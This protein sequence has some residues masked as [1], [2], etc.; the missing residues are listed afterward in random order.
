MESLWRGLIKKRAILSQE[1]IGFLMNTSEGLSQA[2]KLQI[3]NEFTKSLKM[4]GYDK[5]LI[6]WY[7]GL[8]KANEGE[9]TE[10]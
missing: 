1:V 5:S 8:Y 4:S 7:K 6:I 2:V 3:I 9:D 10:Y